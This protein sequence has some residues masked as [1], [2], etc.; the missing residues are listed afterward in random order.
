[1]LADLEHRS[2]LV[3]AVKWVSR[4]IGCLSVVKGV[5]FVLYIRNRMRFLSVC[6]FEEGTCLIHEIEYQAK[7]ERSFGSQSFDRVEVK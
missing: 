1:V 7:E 3:S 2:L 6:L 5:V 4:T